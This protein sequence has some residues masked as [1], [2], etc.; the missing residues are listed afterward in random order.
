MAIRIATDG[1][2]SDVRSIHL[3]AFPSGEGEVVANLA[4]KLL[5]EDTRPAT[6][7]L[8]SAVQG[9]AIGH[10]AF[11]PVTLDGNKRFLGYI[12]APLSVSPE[13]QKQGIGSQLVEDGIRRL[14]TLGVH[15]VLAY[16]DPGYYGKFG[17]SAHI[18]EPYIPPYK[19]QYPWGWQA[20]ALDKAV[21]EGS[22]GQ[23]TCVTA[24]CD[25]VLW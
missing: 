7:S 13:Y 25:P 18:A 17:F 24:L 21:S 22:S 2:R 4:V 12:L 16:G 5:S 9:T 15:T 14:S 10:V 1:D 8:L 11:S 20:L 19:L 3:A 6:M 23:I